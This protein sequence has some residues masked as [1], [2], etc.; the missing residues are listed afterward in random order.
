MPNEL[1][2][3][4]AGGAKVET[5]VDSAAASNRVELSRTQGYQPPALWGLN[6]TQAHWIAHRT[7]RIHD[8]TL[9]ERP[10][11][12]RKGRKKLNWV[13]RDKGGSGSKDWNSRQEESEE[14]DA[15]NNHWCRE[16][17]VSR[18]ENGVG[19]RRAASG[20][21]DGIQEQQG[22]ATGRAE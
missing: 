9:G 15:W 6:V 5:A 3:D 17:F 19:S 20:G 1:R 16:I 22:F 13:E 10:L 11:A 2:V 4:A 12:S 21:R 8:C 7:D 18:A 14:A